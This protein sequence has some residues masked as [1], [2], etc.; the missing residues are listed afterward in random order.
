MMYYIAAIIIALTTVVSKNA[1]AVYGEGNYSVN[2]EATDKGLS[3]VNFDLKLRGRE[4][5]IMFSP[6]LKGNIDLQKKSLVFN[7]TQ[8]DFFNPFVELS[9]GQN[10]LP[11]VTGLTASA[12]QIN[13]A[14]IASNKKLW[15]DRLTPVIFKGVSSSNSDVYGGKIDLASKSGI[16]GNTFYF[17][18]TRS[19]DAIG[20]SLKMPCLFWKVVMET[21]TNSRGSNGT[22]TKG[23]NATETW[24]GMV[25][26]PNAQCGTSTNGENTTE[27][28][29]NS[30]VGTLTMGSPTTTGTQTVV[31]ASSLSTISTV[32]TT[33]YPLNLSMDCS[34]GRLGGDGYKIGGVFKLKELSSDIKYSLINRK[35]NLTWNGS[36]GFKGASFGM[37]Y[38]DDRS[39]GSIINNCKLNVGYGTATVIGNMKLNSEYSKSSGNLPGNDIGKWKLSAIYGTVTAIGNMKL[40]SEYS[41]SNG[42]LPSNDIGKWKITGLFDSKRVGDIK[43]NTEYS[44]SN[45]PWVTN[46]ISIWKCNSEFKL[47]KRFSLSGAFSKDNIIGTN[48]PNGSLGYNWN[49]EYKWNFSKEFGLTLSKQQSYKELTGE[50]DRNLVNYLSGKIDFLPQFPLSVSSEIGLERTDSISK[51]KSKEL[52]SL[53][54]NISLRYSYKGFNPWISYSIT[55]T[56]DRT[57]NNSDI[58]RENITVGVKKKLTRNLTC[59]VQRVCQ[60]EENQ[61]ISRGEMNFAERISTEKKVNLTYKFPNYPLNMDLEFFSRNQQKFNWKISFTF[62]EKDRQ[63]YFKYVSNDIKFTEAKDFRFGAPPGDMTPI[64]KK[65]PDKNEFSKLGVVSV[66]V[67]KDVDANRIFSPNE[68]GLEGIKVIIFEKGENKEKAKAITTEENG[69]ACFVDVPAGIYNL[70]IDLGSVPIDFIC[71]AELE[72][73]IKVEAGNGIELKFP[74]QKAGTVKGRVFR[75]ENRNGAWDAGETGDHDL[76]VYANNVPTF[77]GSGG[78]YRFSN[79]P[80][81][82]I[83]MQVEKSCLPKGY[84]LTTPEFFDVE[85]KPEDEIG[86][87]DF[88]MA[89][90]EM[91]IEF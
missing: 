60:M 74:L 1:F 62:R 20:G 11:N 40:D 46:N 29:E 34:T 41:K 81:G 84:V 68:E 37:G 17:K 63:N 35:Q 27:T 89:E 25:R 43:L 3:S 22:G 4:R 69:K 30:S 50:N 16:I 32:S 31:Q 91:E 23:E 5:L 33:I 6:I 58:N 87:I 73:T 90:Q 86:G 47:G 88:G 15:K 9:V 65:L 75:D 13:G 21:G 44:C 67:F 59:I 38:S 39:A 76:M 49:T 28:V 51:N 78:A 80:P 42:K 61:Y 24:I 52:L 72:Q 10:V 8:A 53:K 14:R 82:K 79:I 48:S 7:Y 18:D 54:R 36:Y 71:V 57:I 19:G 83:R 55:G 45:S 64:S 26:S 85:L 56:D 77:T 2:V 70:N 66:S 12:P